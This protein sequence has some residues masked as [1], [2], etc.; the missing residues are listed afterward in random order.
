S[1]PPPL[2]AALLSDNH[3]TFSTKKRENMT[4]DDDWPLD[5]IV[6]QLREARSDWRSAQAPTHEPGDLELPSRTAMKSIV[7]SLAGALFPMRL[8]PADR[9]KANEAFYVGHTLDQ[10]LNMLL[11]QAMLELR[12]THRKIPLDPEDLL[13][14]ARDIVR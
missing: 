13:Q 14:Q 9:R 1:C 10:A 4:C 2:C 11:Q 12:H 7:E 3:G 5:T 8:G 6:E